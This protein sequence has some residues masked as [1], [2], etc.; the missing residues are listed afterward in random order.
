MKKLWLIIQREYMSRI[1]RR[2]FILGTLLTPLFIGA[3]IFL[4]V[5]LVGY[6]DDNFKKIAV[7]DESGI[8]TKA[9]ANQKNI[10]FTLVT[11]GLDNAKKGVVAKK[12]D[13]VLVI[14]KIVDVT[15][16]RFTIK[17][18][19]DEKIGGD[20]TDD[21]ESKIEDFRGSFIVISKHHLGMVGLTNN[22]CQL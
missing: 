14:P 16:R 12:Y 7:L 4:Q 1:T 3:L 6:K 5:K 2:A 10:N 21:I 22:Y 13:G 15:Q 17:Y 18:Y 11:E 20:M 8:L 19:S 9:P